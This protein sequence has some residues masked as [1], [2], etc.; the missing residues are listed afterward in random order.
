[1][2]YPSVGNTNR[3]MGVFLYWGSGNHRTDLTIQLCRRERAASLAHG[4]VPREGVDEHR[5]HGSL[6]I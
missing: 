5:G 2:H 6:L 3:P 4:P 1:M